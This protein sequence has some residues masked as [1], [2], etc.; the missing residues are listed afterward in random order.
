VYSA[1]VQAMV[2]S[3]QHAGS[4]PEVSRWLTVRGVDPAGIEVEVG[5]T[6]SGFDYVDVPKERLGL[7]VSIVERVANAGGCVE[8]DS[9]IGEGTSITIRWPKADGAAETGTTGDGAII[10]GGLEAGLTS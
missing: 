5:D 8:I 2:N 1:A 9:V 10:G 7:R 6:G 3:L 4:A